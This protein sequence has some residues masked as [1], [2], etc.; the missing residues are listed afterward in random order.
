MP[1]EGRSQRAI[2]ALV[3]AA[4]AS[5]ASPT[6]LRPYRAP[7]TCA[8]RCHIQR[9]LREPRTIAVVNDP[10]RR[11][12][13]YA[14]LALVRPRKVDVATTSSAT[15][16]VPSAPAALSVQARL[17]LERDVH[18]RVETVE[19]RIGEADTRSFPR[20][21]R[22]QCEARAP[23]PPRLAPGA[24]SPRVPLGRQNGR[25]RGTMPTADRDVHGALLL[26][27]TR[28]VPRPVRQS[29]R[30]CGRGPGGAPSLLSKR[31]RVAN[32]SKVSRATSRGR[33]R[34]G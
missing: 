4:R 17:G 33:S 26:G 21:G 32:A 12:R 1:S 22:R 31:E 16:H 24:P 9:Y 7:K 6:I 20:V 34:A 13:V 29:G 18:R 28:P 11:A 10:L 2:A 3:A 5:P 30:I 14:A 15:R 25:E 19:K 27:V 8:A 23:Q